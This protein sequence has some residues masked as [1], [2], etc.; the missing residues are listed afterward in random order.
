MIFNT[1]FFGP[2]RFLSAVLLL[3]KWLTQGARRNRITKISV[4]MY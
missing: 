2:I 4:I 1:F 3:I